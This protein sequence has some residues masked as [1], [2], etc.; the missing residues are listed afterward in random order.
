ML[1]EAAAKGRETEASRSPSWLDAMSTQLALL[2]LDERIMSGPK[3]ASGKFFG[4]TSLQANLR[5]G[6]RA[7][8]AKLAYV[9]EEPGYFAYANSN[10]LID[11]DPSGLVAVPPL[12]PPAEVVG[13]VLTVIAGGGA[14]GGVEGTAAVLCLSDPACVGLAIAVTGA[15]VA[16]YTATHPTVYE[17]GSHSLTDSCQTPRAMI[18]CINACGQNSLKEGDNTWGCCII[19]CC[20]GQPVE[21]ASPV[22]A[23]LGDDSRIK[24]FPGQQ[25][26]KTA[27]P[28][29]PG[30]T[31][32]GITIGNP[33]ICHY[34]CSYGGRRSIKRSDTESCPNWIPL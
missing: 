33:M 23:P 30:C 25:F 12:L 22:C 1:S 31:L 28:E 15:A 34:Q 10:P 26:V 21:Q 6:E 8:G 32:D 19:G 9:S 16:A 4:A 14:G 3:T 2:E 5:Q 11:S 7:V 24:P 13:P 29:K 17:L 20:Y 18:A 27:T